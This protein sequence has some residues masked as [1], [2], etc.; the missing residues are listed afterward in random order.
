M[1]RT[2]EKEVSW[3][4]GGL[5]I[6]VHLALLGA[7]LISFNWKAAHTTLN[8]TE[9]ELWDSIPNQ[10][11]PAPVVQPEPKPIVKE[12]IKPEPKPEP[13]PIVEEKPKEE[14]QVDI[15]LEKKKKH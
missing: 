6:A 12:E 3:K 13:K 5:A 4:A 11:V 7:L 10:A 14:P 1:I 8:V 9:V 15:T 2:Y